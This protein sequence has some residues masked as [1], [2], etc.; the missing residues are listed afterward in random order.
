MLR[1][2]NRSGGLVE[3]IPSDSMIRDF[4]HCSLVGSAENSAIKPISSREITL[5]SVPNAHA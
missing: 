2:V 1:T 3:A 5:L 4:V